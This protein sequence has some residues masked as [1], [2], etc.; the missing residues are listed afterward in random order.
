[1]VDI[2]SAGHRFCSGWQEMRTAAHEMTE[3]QTPQGDETQEPSQG[4]PFDMLGVKPENVQKFF[5]QRDRFDTS[6]HVCIC[7]HA[8]NKHS[9]YEE[10]HGVCLTGRHYCPCKN[11]TPV[12]VSNDTRYFMRKT[13]GPGSKHALVAG[14]MRLR[15]VGKQ[16]TWLEAPSCWTPDCNSG[17]KLIFPVAL[18]K[19]NRVLD[20]P[21]PVNVFLCETCVLTLKGVPGNEGKGWIW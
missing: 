10:G 14:L 18:D 20:K 1:M 16:A 9:G 5:D 17:N 13:Y 12:L 3:S 11:Q 8:I 6:K 15:H 7:G 2:E 4:S 21:G 19:T